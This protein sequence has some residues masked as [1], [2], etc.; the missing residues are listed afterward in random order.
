M[1]SPNDPDFVKQAGAAVADGTF[2]SVAGRD[3]STYTSG[4]AAQFVS[5]YAA[6]YPGQEPS[7]YGAYAY[8]AAMVLITAIRHLITAGRTVTRAA[9]VDEVEHIQYAGVTGPISFDSNGDIGHGV[10]SMYVVQH[11][12]WTYAWQVK[13]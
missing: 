10:I 6:R 4:A 8:D 3:P 1:A 7:F 2:A 13:V 11:G 12:R 9:L 5:D